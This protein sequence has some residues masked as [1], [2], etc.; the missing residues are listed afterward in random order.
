MPMY[1]RLIRIFLQLIVALL[2]TVSAS[3]G[4]LPSYD[5]YKEW[6]IACDNGL[7]CEARG[8]S[9]KRL[10][11]QLS[12]LRE[13][14]P[15]G[16]LHIT[17][18]APFRFNLSGL[19]MDGADLSLG[20]TEKIEVHPSRTIVK[21]AQADAARTF[22]QKIRNGN[23]L[24][25]RDQDSKISLSG[26]TAALLRMDERQQRL[27][28]QTAL[29]RRGRAPANTIAPPP[30]LPH[31]EKGESAPGLNHEEERTLLDAV[32]EF[33]ANPLNTYCYG[34]MHLLT[35]V[36]TRAWAIDA[37]RAL[38]AVPCTLTNIRQVQS[39]MYIADRSP[40]GV[41]ELFQPSLHFESSAEPITLIALSE[42]DFDPST[43]RLFASRKYLSSATCGHA[44]E[45]QWQ[46]GK[47]ILAHFTRQNH[48]GGNTPGNWP[49][50]YRSNAA[51]SFRHDTHMREYD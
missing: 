19:D 11:P 16:A 41:I 51:S 27:G 23:Y 47:F 35:P 1:R 29:I 20:D 17:I 13:A 28:T 9:T 37:H 50:I 43:G 31:I 5:H 12:I 7:R 36:A 24:E 25:F 21:I 32:Q 10:A 18:A 34:A 14:G 33:H 44:G 39:F 22:I 45:W 2:A 3:A 26:L 40:G 6:L 46:N 38:V 8:M 49:V 30:P 48:C 42:P 4:V 15:E